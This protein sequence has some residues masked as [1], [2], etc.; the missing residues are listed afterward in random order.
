MIKG[1]QVRLLKSALAGFFVM[2]TLKINAC[3]RTDA[4]SNR[5]RIN[6]KIINLSA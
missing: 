1:L 6:D 5:Q 4:A 2:T 3:T